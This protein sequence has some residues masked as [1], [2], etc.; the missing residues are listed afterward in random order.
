MEQITLL[1][2]EVN[3]LVAS[4]DKQSTLEI[5]DAIEAQFQLTSPSKV[6]ISTL[7]NT[8]PNLGSIASIG[9]FLI[10]LIDS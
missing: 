3:N 2:Q 5:V 10:S 1:R 4:D 7:I 6:V 9:S 8:L